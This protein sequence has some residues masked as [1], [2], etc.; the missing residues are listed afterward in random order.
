MSIDTK[1]IKPFVLPAAIV[2][3]LVFHDFCRILSP[4]VPYIIFSILILTFASTELRRLKFERLDLFLML[5]QIAATFFLY[6]AFRPLFSDP[7]V[8][9]GLMMAALCPVAC[10]VTVVATMLGAKRENTVAYTI[11]G[12]LLICLLAP[13][14]FIIIGDNPE[15]VSLT[16]SFYAIFGKIVTVIGLPF[17]IMLPIQLWARPV[18]KALRRANGLAFYL[19]G[20]ALFLTLG[21]TIDFIFLHGEGHWDVILYL[22]IGSVILCP[23]QFY[24]GRKIGKRCGDAIAGQQLLGQK[25]SAM[26]IWMANTYL[27]PLASTFLAFYSITQ[28]L[29]NSWQIWRKTSTPKKI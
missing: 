3:G 27:N 19:W 7:A 16:D 20:A 2:F 9:E 13:V 15:T 17:F 29:L 26:G 24:I 6:F 22:G 28:N 4:C 21:Q 18:S 12:N 5:F 23:L 8:A 1:R 14:M 10:S 11:V 25:N